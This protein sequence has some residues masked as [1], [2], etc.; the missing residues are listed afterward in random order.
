MARWK[1]VAR[2]VRDELGEGAHW[3]PRDGALY[4]VDI[5]G[6][7]LNRLTIDS[8]AVERWDVPE[9]LG[10]VA[11]RRA[12]GLVGGFRSG[13]AAI[14][15]GPLA[16]ETIAN[17][18]PNLPGNRM[19]DGKVDRF[20]AIWCG[21]MDMAEKSETGSLYRFTPDGRWIR[22]DTG[23]Q[24]PNGPAFSA[25][26]EWLYHADSAKRVIYRYEYGE[27]GI[28]RRA[29]FIHFSESDGHPDGMTVDAEDGLWVAHWDG[30]R[31]SRFDRQGR[32]DRTIELPARRITSI[33]LAGAALDRMF[34][35]SAAT[36]LDPTGFDGALFEVESGV[37]GLPAR[38]Y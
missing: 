21:T 30:G 22:A 9:P 25:C 20:G 34:V 28:A 35:T 1:I 10:W 15:L 16:I 3:S 11:E 17:P 32:L 19:N 14:S 12:G 31:I 38:S 26:G 13:L 7:A 29:P 8:G 36:G 18:E 2:D 6:C 5:L 33:V 37:R 24:V 23:Y 4:W 27:R